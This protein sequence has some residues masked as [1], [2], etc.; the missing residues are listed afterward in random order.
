ML[1]HYISSRTQDYATCETEN[2]DSKACLF[3][4]RFSS[5]I[6][7]F[8]ISL[9][10][11]LFYFCT[12][13]RKKEDF[14]LQKLFNIF[15]IEMLNSLI[16]NR[17]SSSF[18]KLHFQNHCFSYIMTILSFTMMILSFTS[19]ILVPQFNSS[20]PFLQLIFL[21]LIVAN[22]LAHNLIGNIITSHTQKCIKH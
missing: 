21:I 22:I 15:I 10:T 5:D 3:Q 20:N 12:I 2:Q 8:F 1:R 18:C 17:I 11:V 4:L 7:Q 9:N 16:K 13:S 19:H 6:F 14:G